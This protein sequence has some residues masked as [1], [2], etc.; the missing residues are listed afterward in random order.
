[1]VEP[2]VAYASYIDMMD[3][4][5]A[6]IL[7]VVE[8]VLNSLL[9][10]RAHAFGRGPEATEQCEDRQ[11]DDRQNGDLAESVKAPEIDENDIDDVTP[12]ALRIGVLD[13]VAGKSVGE[14]P[15]HYCEGQEG[16]PG[17]GDQRDQEVASAPGADRKRDFALG[18]MH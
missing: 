4:G 12:A 18:M 6:M 10:G 9:L 2:E 5:E 14:R 17:S 8:R 13:E 1:M 11:R 3:L 15:G 7:K 16:H